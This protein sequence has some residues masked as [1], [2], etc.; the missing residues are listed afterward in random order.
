LKTLP[1]LNAELINIGKSPTADVYAQIEEDLLA[2]SAVLPK[3]YSNAADVGRV[4]KG[5]AWGLLAKARLYQQ[6]WLGVLT[7]IDSVEEGGL[8]QLEELYTDNFNST[9]QN[10]QES[11]F[12]IQHL[13]GQTPKLGSHLNQWFGAPDNNGYYF[14]VPVQNFVA[15]FESNSN[16]VPDPR[17]DYTV[18]RSGQPWINPGAFDPTW[19]PTGYLQKKHL[20]SLVEEPVVGDAGINYVYLRY[21]DVLLMKAEAL[22]EL[23]R[24]GEAIVPLNAV[25]K[26]ARES[27]LFDL[28]LPGAGTIPVGL[29]ADVVATNQT[30]VRDAIRHERRVELGF[31]F[32]RYFDLMR[33]GQQAAEVALTNTNFNYTNNRYFLIPQSEIDTNTAIDE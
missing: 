32:H 12:E 3:Q 9:A 10:N 5:A 17:L 31:E 29:L 6:Q 7:A 1:H 18:G 14:N 16:G 2:A 11:I 33:Y 21:A 20:Q 26:R 4:T 28:N 19:S 30:S 13:S 24:V 8:Y 15:E 23:N 22:N 25:R 27:Y